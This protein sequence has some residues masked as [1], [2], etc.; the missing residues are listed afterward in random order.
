MTEQQ[1]RLPLGDILKQVDAEM[2]NSITST[3]DLANEY[4]KKL[5]KPPPVTGLLKER[6]LTHG[7]YTD[8]AEITQGLKYVMAGARNWDRL[9]AVQR[10]TLEMVAH[11]IGRILAGDPTFKDH[12]DDIEG[13]VRLT[14]ERL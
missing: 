11:K 13:Y 1:K 9:T 2:D 6:G 8:H 4:A 10:E 12:W 5:H 3:T 14:V 7:D